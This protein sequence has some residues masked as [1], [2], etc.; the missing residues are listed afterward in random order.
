MRHRPRPSAPS[1]HR[2]THPGSPTLRRARQQALR[3][4]RAF[5][6]PNAISLTITFV[7]GATAGDLLARRLPDTQVTVGL[8][9]Y[10]AQA[11]VLL[12]TARRFD[13]RCKRLL[14]PW[15]RTHAQSDPEAAARDGVGAGATT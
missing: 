9:L 6:T 5:L 7:L 14:D 15:Q 10:F 11:A 4:D 8:V 3:L 1:D 13:R 2:D 12:E